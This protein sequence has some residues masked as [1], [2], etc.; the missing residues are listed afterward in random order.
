MPRGLGDVQEWMAC[1]SFPGHGGGRARGKASREYAT[2]LLQI[3]PLLLLP[4]R[5]PS[6][7]K[8]SAP[9]LRSLPRSCFLDGL[10]VQSRSE[11]ERGRGGE[12]GGGSACKVCL[13]ELDP[14]SLSLS[15]PS[16]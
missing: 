14:P 1:A 8:L 7:E 10:T 15:L 13:G 9:S 3:S 11:R 2:N 16:A 12:G 5:L 6:R 4:S